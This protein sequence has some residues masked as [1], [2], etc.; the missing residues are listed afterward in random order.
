MTAGTLSYHHLVSTLPIEMVTKMT[1]STQSQAK[2]NTAYN[3][4]FLS[5]SL[6]KRQSLGRLQSYNGPRSCLPTNLMPKCQEPFP[7]CL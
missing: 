1:I 3:I 5:V 6:L 4:R 7:Q 2:F